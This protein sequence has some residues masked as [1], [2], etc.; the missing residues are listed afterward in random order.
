MITL[1]DLT[2]RLEGVRGTTS[3]C[4]AHDDNRNSLSF[5]LGDD[6]RILLNC[7]AGCAFNDIVA[8][9]NLKPAD[10]MPDHPKKSKFPWADP[11]YITTIYQYRDPDGA[12]AFQ[13]LRGRD[14]NFIQRHRAGNAWKWGRGD[15]PPYLYRLP[16]LLSARD[17]RKAIFFVEGEKD[18]DNLA[19][20]GLQVTSAPD[21]AKTKWHA[22][23]TEWI[24][25]GQVFVI[26]DNDEPGH[27][28]ARLVVSKLTN[29]VIVTLPGI[30]PKQDVSDWLA[31]GGTRDALID[32]ARR[33]LDSPPIDP[34]PEPVSSAPFKILGYDNGQFFFLPA[35]GKQVV[36]LSDAALS[37]KTAL[38]QLA[39]I[40]YWES[41]YHG[42]SS[43][44]TYAANSLIQSCYDRGI[45]D[46]NDCRGRGA[47]WDDGHVVVHEGNRLIIDGDTTDLSDKRT[48]RIYQRA[49]PLRIAREATIA[50]DEAGQFV[51]L[52]D[53]LNWEHPISAQLLAGWIVCAP[54]CGALRWRPHIWLTGPAGSGKSWTLENI[55]SN[56]IGSIALSVQSVSTEAGLRQALGHDARPVIFDEAETEDSRAAM[57]IQKVLELAR[58]ASSEG[59][60]RIVKGTTGGHAQ[61]FSIRSMFCLSSIGVGVKRRADVTRVTV[62]PF[63]R[64]IL[65]PDGTRHFEAIQRLQSEVVT[66]EFTAGLISMACGRAGVIRDNA[67]TFAVA[68]ANALGSRRT[69]DQLGTLLAG[70]WAL[71]NPSP[72]TLAEAS[73]YVASNHLDALTPPDESTDEGQCLDWLLERRIEVDIDGKP[74]RRTVWEVIESIAHPTGTANLAAAE[75]ALRRYGMRYEADGLHVSNSHS[76]L[77]EAFKD[78]PWGGKKWSTFL[79]RLDGVTGTSGTV[80]FA[81]GSSRASIIPL[82][83]IF[84]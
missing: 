21:G 1:D 39:D 17:A 28:L 7:H 78:T 53:S 54:I 18:A 44:A 30:G 33:A 51:E 60:S 36:A 67:A 3:R 43:W 8:A 59:G 47:W 31:A 66:A 10:L 24:G 12:D 32:I 14:K 15:N 34:T 25:D 16:D 71:R 48:K 84:G 61:F 5:K 35:S 50:D 80:R 69:G 27:A 75:S 40:N 68:V 20:I 82:C 72:I 6:G 4:P 70:Y 65:G 37:R 77:V 46:P 19:A 42:V 41:V 52:L 79:R 62:L 73:E 13:K 64:P 76:A 22:Q 38:L 56:C 63:K 81:G 9:I 55:I 29:A 2:A 11:D 57:N 45:F 23:Y 26:P 74:A 83:H 58:Q 49:A